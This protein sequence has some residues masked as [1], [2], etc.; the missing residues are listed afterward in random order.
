MNRYLTWGLFIASTSLIIL[1]VDAFTPQK[2]LNSH[3]F[4]MDILI[5]HLNFTIWI[6]FLT[7]I[8]IFYPSSNTLNDTLTMTKGVGS[9]FTAHSKG[10]LLEPPSRRWSK[11]SP[12]NENI[13]WSSQGSS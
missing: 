4:T 1:C 8:L 10:N 12:N 3:K 2:Y 9:S 11:H 7:L 5:S 13:S 6:V